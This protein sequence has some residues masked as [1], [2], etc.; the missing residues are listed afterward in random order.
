MLMMRYFSV[1]FAL[2]L[3]LTASPIWA[4]SSERH[5]GVVVAAD[6][7]RGTITIDEMGPWYGPATAPARRVFQIAPG[8]RFG[9]AE[10]TPDG[11]L[12]WPWAYTERSL[13]LSDLRA[14]DFVTITTEPQGARAVA[15]QVQAVRPTAE[16]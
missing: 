3:L 10:R 12:G 15:V 9:L 4:A 14:G 1:G 2:G 11:N 8:T 16:K 6:P 13:E 7:G 5:S